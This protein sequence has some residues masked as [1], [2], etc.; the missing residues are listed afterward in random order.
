MFST[1]VW[2]NFTLDKSFKII[3]PERAPKAGFAAN[4]RQGHEELTVE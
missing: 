3:T 2:T 4:L 1:G